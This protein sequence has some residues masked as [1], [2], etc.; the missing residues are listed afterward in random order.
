[1]YG[2]SLIVE[3]HL[4]K[5]ETGV[6]VCVCVCACIASF[7]FVQKEMGGQIMSIYLFIYLF[8]CYWYALG[9]NTFLFSQLFVA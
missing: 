3:A 4:M 5:M 1:M 2:P 6:C 8:F 9:F 7:A